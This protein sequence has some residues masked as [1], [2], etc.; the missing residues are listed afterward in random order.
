[1]DGFLVQ[2]KK[3][4]LKTIQPHRTHKTGYPSWWIRRG[5]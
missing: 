1:L 4:R 5:P 3:D 2:L